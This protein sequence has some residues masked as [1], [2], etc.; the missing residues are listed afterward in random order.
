MRAVL[1]NPVHCLSFRIGYHA[2]FASLLS[3]C[4]TSPQTSSIFCRR[5]C[6]CCATSSPRSCQQSIPSGELVASNQ[7]RQANLLPAINPVRRTCC[8]QS[9]PSGELV[10]SNQSRQANLLPAINPV[11]RTCQQSITSGELAHLFSILSL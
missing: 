1:L 6:G 3:D 10:A 4:T 5:S 11:R 2:P 7:F 8:Q 9:I